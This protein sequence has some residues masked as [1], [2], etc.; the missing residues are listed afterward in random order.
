MSFCTGPCLLMCTVKK[1]GVPLLEQTHPV[2][3]V[4]PALHRDALK[5]SQHGKCKVIKVCDSI[6]W[7]LPSHHALRYVGRGAMSSMG[8]AWGTGGR[9]LFRNSTWAEIGC[10]QWIWEKT[11][12]QWLQQMLKSPDLCVHL[13]RKNRFCASCPWRARGRWWHKWWWRTELAER[14]AGGEPWL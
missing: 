1:C 8:R 9:L 7:T 14:C 11:R 4:S 12:G 3:D 2:Q 13:W 10:C 6:I 5:H